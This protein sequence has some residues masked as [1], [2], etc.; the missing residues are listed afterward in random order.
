MKDGDRTLT[1]TKQL[2]LYNP[3]N[4]SDEQWARFE[5]LKAMER[6]SANRGFRM[7]EN[8]RTRI[9]FFCGKFEMKPLVFSH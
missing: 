2:S 9:L 4:L 5:F 7:F 3:E 6:K 8:H 1:G